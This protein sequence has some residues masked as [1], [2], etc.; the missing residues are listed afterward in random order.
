MSEVEA[1]G[2]RMPAEWEPHEATWL[3][4]PHLGSDW[5]GK[6]SAVRWAFAEFVR[7]LESREWV[8]L[9]VRNTREAERGAQPT[10]AERRRSGPD[11]PACGP[12]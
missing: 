4:Y 1:G 8:R 5:P 11:R 12:H 9:L 7:I 10:A 3:A 6:L 2:T